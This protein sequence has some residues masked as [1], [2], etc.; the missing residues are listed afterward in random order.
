MSRDSRLLAWV[1]VA[2]ASDLADIAWEL[3]FG[4]R[5][6]LFTELIRAALLVP[7]VFLAS[8]YLRTFI[9]TLIAFLL[10]NWLQRSIEQH[11]YWFQH[12]PTSTRMYLDAYLAF[13]PSLFIALTLLLDHLK[14][15]EIY[16]TP[17]NLNARVRG[18][19][20]LRWSVLA[21]AI[22]LFMVY[23]LSEQL[24][25]ILGDV[26]VARRV[27]WLSVAALALSFAAI[28]AANEEFRFRFV[29]LARGRRAVGPSA[30]L[31][32]TSLNFGLA[33]WDGHPGGPTGVLSTTLFAALLCR[34]LY[35]TEGGLWAWL[36]HVGGD[37]IIIVVV[38]LRVG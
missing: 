4:H 26:H 5:L 28:N 19:G 1:A 15:S 17:G 20:R 16:L 35:D 21:P 18:L 32:L 37:I 12:A 14:P 30:A 33:H 24:R 6:P 3:R 25:Y 9:V 34:S 10:G 13:I 2:V 7:L 31:W 23:G 8:D 11:W 22:I 38:L 36:M 29:L 27:G